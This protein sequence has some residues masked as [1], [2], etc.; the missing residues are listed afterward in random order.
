[1]LIAL[2]F[3]AGCKP[4]GTGTPPAGST[5]GL[6]IVATTAMVAELARNVVGTH[7]SVRTLMSAGVDPHL[8]K[9]TTSDVADIQQA[10]VVFYNG[11]G[12]EGPMQPV[13]NERPR[14]V[15]R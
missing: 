6:Q 10:N 14:R 2:A 7:G 8:Y 13:S 3:M 15:R 4:A 9:P 5:G 11:L 12:L 1:M